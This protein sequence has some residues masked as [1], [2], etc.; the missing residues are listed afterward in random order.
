MTTTAT[1][2]SARGREILDFARGAD[3][4][5]W[6]TEWERP[7]WAIG[8]PEDCWT[9]FTLTAVADFEAELGF[10]VEALGLDVFM[11]QQVGHPADATVTMAMLAPRVEGGDAPFIIGIRAADDEHPA[12]PAGSTTFEFMTKDLPAAWERIT[13]AG[14]EVVR[15]PWDDGWMDRAIARTP[16]GFEV[17]LWSLGARR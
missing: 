2:F 14:A 3:Q 7:T 4:D 6:K 17:Q 15:E 8:E 5:R 11:L 10:L 13:A 1:D 9:H 16:N 12:A